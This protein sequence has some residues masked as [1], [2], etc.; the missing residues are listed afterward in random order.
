[1]L[2]GQ[3][4]AELRDERPNLLHRAAKHGHPVARA[5]IEADSRVN[6]SL[7]EMAVVGRRHKRMVAQQGIETAQ[8]VAEP[9]GRNR[10]ILGA[11]P[12]SRMAGLECA[13]AETRLAKPPNRALLERIGE[14][15]H[16]A[17]FAYRLRRALEF[18]RAQT[19]AVR[20]FG[21]Q[22]DNEKRAAVGQKPHAGQSFGSR[23]IRQMMVET[24]ERFGA[25]PQDP[26]RLIRGR[27]NVLEAQHDQ[28]YRPRAWNELQ[29][30]AQRDSA[31]ALA[32][33]QRSRKM[34]P[35]LGEK[36]VEVV[37]RD[38]AR[39]A[40]EVGSYRVADTI[41]KVCQRPYDFGLPSRSFAGG[42]YRLVIH[43]SGQPQSI[44]VVQD[45]IDGFHIINGLAVGGGMRA[46]GV[47]PD[48]P[49]DRASVLSRRVGGEE[50]SMGSERAV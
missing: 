6:A 10:D 35:L 36:L 47:V 41:A 11:G 44:A 39:D 25:M 50:Q 49:A 14:N 17:A 38:A 7:A 20:R 28:D 31:G 8:I 5:E 12:G 22:L 4:T 33:D 46:A 43:R 24:F 19:G 18:L 9:L 15:A 30:R 27:V 48:H 40:R 42:A 1:M 32:A 26:R 2:S 45:G 13:S 37:A 34:E 29:C 21:S 16:A 23:E 3:G